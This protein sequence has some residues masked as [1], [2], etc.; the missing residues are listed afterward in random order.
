VADRCATFEPAHHDAVRYTTEVGLA[1][2]RAVA[3]PLHD[4]GWHEELA[5][6]N[7]CALNP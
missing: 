4:R 7:R 1:L 5:A 6:I 2:G 3:A